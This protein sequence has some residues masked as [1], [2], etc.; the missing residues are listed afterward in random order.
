MQI[1]QKKV[2]KKKDVVNLN[3]KLIIN[4]DILGKEKINLLLTIKN[5]FL[6]IFNHNIALIILIHL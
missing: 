4:Y 3:I 6:I 2:L 1:K 5:Q